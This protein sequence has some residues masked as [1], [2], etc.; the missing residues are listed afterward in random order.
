MKKRILIICTVLVTVSFSSFAYMNWNN[1]K[2]CKTASCEEEIAACQGS[3]K[4]IPRWE[5]VGI[6]NLNGY[7]QRNINFIY[8]IDSRFIWNVTKA[9]INKATSILDIYPKEATE[10]MSDFSNVQVTL[11]QDGEEISEF[12]DSEQL[13]D[14]QKK[15]LENLDYSS[16]FYV[17]AD[18]GK[19]NYVT[20]QNTNYIVYYITVVPEKEATY[21]KGNDG[22]IDYLRTNSQAEAS[23][24]ETDKLQPGRI[25]FTVTKEGKVTNVDLDATSGYIALDKKMVD[26]ITNLPEKWNAATNAKGEKVEQELVFFFGIEGC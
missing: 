20:G 17:R 10:G 9:Q 7:N 6:Y 4:V 11:M 2:N 26:L 14:A 5:N 19:F 23:M 25:N 3:E 1:S 21:A 15:L 13:N 12:G 18:Y 16:N 22:L 24:V 8:K